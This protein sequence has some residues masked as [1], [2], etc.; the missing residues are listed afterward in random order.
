[1]I[2]ALEVSC[3]KRRRINHRGH[4]GNSK[5][6]KESTK[7]ISVSDSIKN[8]E[9]LILAI[10]TATRAGSVAIAR[11]TQLLSSRVGDA[12]VSHST[13]LIEMIEQAL[14]E[15]NAQLS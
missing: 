14:Q 15:A 6:N 7:T 5:S 9:P 3:V 13:N 4:R 11:G 8:V 2:I 1:M 10:E 12:E